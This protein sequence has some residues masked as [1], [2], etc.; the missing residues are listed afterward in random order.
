M[1]MLRMISFELARRRNIIRDL[2]RILVALG[3]EAVVELDV[4][5]GI[6]GS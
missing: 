4:V 6:V 3:K 1:T 2:G 5:T